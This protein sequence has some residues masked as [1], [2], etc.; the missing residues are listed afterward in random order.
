[1][2]VLTKIREEAWN[3]SVGNSVR[4]SPLVFSPYPPG[5]LSY[6]RDYSVMPPT[7]EMDPS[8]TYYLCFAQGRFDNYA[9]VMLRERGGVREM[10]FPRDEYYFSRLCLLAQA[11]GRERVYRD[12]QRLYA[13]TSDAVSL[14]VLQELRRISLE[15]GEDGPL[16]YDML[17]HVYYGMVAEEHYQRVYDGVPEP[18]RTRM[19][20]LM[21]MHALHR[22]LVEMDT[23]EAASSECVDMSPDLIMEQALEMGLG[24]HVTWT[25][26][27]TMYDDPARLPV[28]RAGSKKGVY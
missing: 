19:G 13:M 7:S 3:A 24:R 17:L 5:G 10:F 15:Y 16:A 26:Y 2:D 8:Y 20:K 21:K 18:K 4:R 14:D 1:M 11:Y 25:P 12:C 9:A 28:V 23:V 27:S 22:M 6:E